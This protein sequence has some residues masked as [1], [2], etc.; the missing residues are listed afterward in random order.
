MSFII[1]D[2]DNMYNIIYDYYLE[3]ASLYQAQLVSL[4]F[5]LKTKDLNFI[6]R[7]DSWVLD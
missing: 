6:S 4:K 3:V 5:F 2:T 1:H 7:G